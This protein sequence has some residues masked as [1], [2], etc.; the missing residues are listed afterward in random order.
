[1]LH[2][3][4]NPFLDLYACSGDG[5]RAAPRSFAP[6]AEARPAVEFNYRSDRRGIPRRELAGHPTRRVAAPASALRFEIG[7]RHGWTCTADRGLD[8]AA[9]IR[10]LRR[11]RRR[12]NPLYLQGMGASAACR[13]NASN[14]PR[15]PKSPAGFPYRRRCGSVAWRRHSICRCKTRVLPFFH[16]D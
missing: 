8:G 6:N 11:A 3:T 10:V 4:G 16:R 9:G 1:M 2:P 13:I 12:P 14:K 5:S 15:S 7:W